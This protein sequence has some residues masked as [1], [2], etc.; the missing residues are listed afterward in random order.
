M[1]CLSRL[2]AGLAAMLLCAAAAP[3]DFV[4]A[5]LELVEDDGPGGNWTWRVYADF[6]DPTNVLLAI[7]AVLDV[8]EWHF[9]ADTPL[10]NDGGVLADTKAEDF[11][12]GDF[13]GP[14]D[15]WVTIG[16]DLGFPSPTDYS[17]GFAGSD[18]KASVILGVTLS[19]TDGGWF[20]NV[21]GTPVQGTHILIGQFTVASGSNFTMSGLAIWE[22]TPSFTLWDPEGGDFITSFFEVAIEPL[23]MGACCATDGT[24]TVATVGVCEFEGGVYQGDDTSCDPNPCPQP[25]GACCF[26]DGSCTVDEGASCVD[27]G[28]V[29]QGDDTTCVPNP[30]PQPTGACCRVDGL[31]AIVSQAECDVVGGTYQGDETSCDPGLC[32]PAGACC[33]P[34]GSCVLLTE[35]ACLA[36]AGVYEGDETGCFPN[37]CPPPPVGFAGASLELVEDDGPGGNWTWRVYLEFKGGFEVL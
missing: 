30:C 4:G 1:H 11:P 37:P 33:F 27:A 31:C 23:A 32:P 9:D 16:D 2:P 5:S 8:A 7:G 19:E 3:A 15:S 22:P 10:V 12:S 35:A 26:D 28:G 18:G 21:P 34:D 14:R 29:F 24:C 6:D 25:M 13:A 17:P 20:N 36:A